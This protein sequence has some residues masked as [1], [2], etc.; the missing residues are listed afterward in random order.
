[1]SCWFRRKRSSSDGAPIVY[2]LDRSLFVETPVVVRKRGK[3]QAIIDRVGLAIAVT[4]RP[5]L[6]MIRVANDAPPS[7]AGDCRR[8]CCRRRGGACA[9]ASGTNRRADGARERVR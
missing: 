6:D 4:R 8:R 1:M 3:E 2:K 9:S 7:P 5:Q